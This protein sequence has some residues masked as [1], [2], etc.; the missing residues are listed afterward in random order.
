MGFKAEPCSAV[1]PSATAARWLVHTNVPREGKRRANPDEHL[2]LVVVPFGSGHRSR[3]RC[4]L[5]SCLPPFLLP[6]RRKTSRHDRSRSRRKAE[7]LTRSRPRAP[8]S[9][10][11]PNGHANTSPPIEG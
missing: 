10:P 11:N 5:P 9:I 1:P 8:A 4:P 3:G 6:H 7:P 2:D